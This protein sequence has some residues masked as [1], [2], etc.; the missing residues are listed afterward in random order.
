MTTITAL[1]NK[2]N[3]KMNET[4]S[5]SEIILNQIKRALANSTTI[6]LHSSTTSAEVT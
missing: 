6:S 1:Y 4:K 5:E 3:N 2:T